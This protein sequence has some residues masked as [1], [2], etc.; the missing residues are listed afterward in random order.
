MNNFTSI[1]FLNNFRSFEIIKTRFWVFY[2]LLSTFHCFKKSRYNFFLSLKNAEMKDRYFTSP[3][4]IQSHDRSKFSFLN[5]SLLMLSIKI[6]KKFLWADSYFCYIFLIIGVIMF[7][8]L[9]VNTDFF[10]VEISKEGEGWNEWI[11]KLLLPESTITKKTFSSS[12]PKIQ[13]KI[14]FL[15]PPLEIKKPPKSE[16]TT[17]WEYLTTNRDFLFYSFV[18]MMSWNAALLERH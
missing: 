11:F 17:L 9:F 2:D 8:Q 12:L 3:S 16:S 10:T 18:L 6:S 4:W 13:I 14:E 15:K 7:H 1:F 5:F